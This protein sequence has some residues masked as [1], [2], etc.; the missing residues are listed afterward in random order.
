MLNENDIE[1][2]Q[3]EKAEFTIS[4]VLALGKLKENNN[5]DDV[6]LN[7]NLSK[8]EIYVFVKSEDIET[9]DFINRT[10]TE[11]EVEQKYFPELFIYQS[12]CKMNIL[13]RKVVKV[14]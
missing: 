8:L 13:P 2:I 1:R 9:E 14:C 7:F 11:W 4:L 3:P 12:D 6:Y 10:I 5:V